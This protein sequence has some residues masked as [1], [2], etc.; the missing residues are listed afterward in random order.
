[1]RISTIQGRVL[2]ALSSVALVAT[3]VVASPAHAA[4][5][6]PQCD[7]KVPVSSCAGATSDGAPFAMQVPANFNGTVILWSHGYRPNVAV[8]AGI[9]GYGGYTVKNTPETAGGQQ[10]GDF[11]ATNYLLSQG[12]ALMGSGFA[13]QGW[14][15]DSALAT[16]VELVSTFKTQFPKT[17]RVL[18]WGNSLGGIITQVLAEKYPTLVSA[19]APLCMA[20]N[21]A[22]ELT[23][24]G[25]FLWGVKTLF[26]PAIKGGNY[27]AG[28]A[29]YVEAM[30]DLKLFFTVLGELQ[31]N[32]ATGKWPSTSSPAGKA[33]EAAGIPSRSALLL[34]G[35]AAGIPT[36]SAHF[37][38]ISGPEGALKLSFPLAV[39]P[40]LAILENGANSG[41]LAV[42][43]LSDVE[44]QVGGAVFD[45]TKTDYSARVADSAV[46]FN[47]ALSG[48][49]AINAMLGV[50]ATAPRAAANADAAAK[51]AKLAATTGKVNVPTIMMVGVADPITPAGA[52]QR[53]VDA[54]A[55]QK[56]AEKAAAIAEA[57]SSKNYTAPV[58]KLA[59]LWGTTPKSWTTFDENGAPVT[60][61]AGAPGTGHCNFSSAQWIAAA[62]LLVASANAGQIPNGGLVANTARRAGNLSVD[63]YFRAPLLKYY[64]E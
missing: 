32:M 3:V 8:P 13:R 43:A 15:L 45:N 42:L 48:N 6:A 53:I 54:Y 34:L 57:K 14:N 52:T 1:M 19:V 18:A 47:A 39:S 10:G 23:A 25:D 12:Y 35:L 40:A 49:T 37:D 21:I 60:T 16:N 11:A 20:D 44:A 41:A 9:P 63:K 51:L 33:L 61:A 38:S 17:T 29:G 27:S 64:N 22:P 62:K 46:V 2:A 24:A 58:N 28:A 55:E 36:Q 4:A 56:A 26:N 7:G 50:L 59:V 30:T 31:A 5:V